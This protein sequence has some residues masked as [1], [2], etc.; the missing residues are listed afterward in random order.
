[1]NMI[2]AQNEVAKFIVRKFYRWF[3]YYEIDAATEANVITPL[4]DIFRSNGYNI[5]PVLTTLFKSE[6]FFD[7]LNQNC[8]IKTP[9][10]IAIGSAREFNL[11]MPLATDW[12]TSYGHWKTCMTRQ[13]FPE[14]LLIIRNRSFMRYGSLPIL[15]Q[16]EISLLI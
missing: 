1:M 9:V 8:V 16:K 5:K 12:D 14:C 11:N 7:V 6:H 10:D 4:A 13:T 3:V 2:F 15:F